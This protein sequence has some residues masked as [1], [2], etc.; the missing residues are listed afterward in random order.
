MRTLKK[1]LPLSALALLVSQ[2]AQA[3][4]TF[5][6]LGSTFGLG[7]SDLE[8]TVINIVQWA[9]GLLALIAVVI[10]IVA[11]FTW[12]TAAGNEE[13]ISKAKGMITAA[14]IGLIV[15]LLAWAIVIFVVGT[16]TNVTQ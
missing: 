13:K 14:V 11:G 16:T 6:N 4:V 1:A 7:T 5:K 8:Q 10:I 3:Q 2:A 9:L 15:V 12:I